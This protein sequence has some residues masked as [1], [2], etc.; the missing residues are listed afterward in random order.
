LGRWTIIDLIKDGRNW[1]AYVGNDPVNFVDPMGLDSLYSHFDKDREK[2]STYYFHTTDN[3]TFTGKVAVD[4]FTATNNVQKTVERTIPDKELYIPESFPNG[5]WNLDQSVTKNNDA[6]GPLII[7]TNAS[8]NVQTL[9]PDPLN[10]GSYIPSGGSVTDWGYG[11]HGGGYTSDETYEPSENNRVEDNTFGCIRLSNDDIITLANL[12][13]AAIN[14]KN[15]DSYVIVT[16]GK[17]ND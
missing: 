5:R 1:Y 16:G 4:S 11:F 7:P 13:D 2:L 15:G 17:E 9:I 3:G 8:R 6:F 12:S 14:S 10:P